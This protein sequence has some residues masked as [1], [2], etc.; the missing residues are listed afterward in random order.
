MEIKKSQNTDA[1]D[2][3]NLGEI[4]P[5]NQSAETGSAINS[6]GATVKTLNSLQQNKNAAGLF[7]EANKA[8]TVSS[9][10]DPGLSGQQ[11]AAGIDAAVTS[12]T[13]FGSTAL[14]SPEDANKVEDQR[15]KTLLNRQAIKEERQQEGLLDQ[16]LQNESNN[17]EIGEQLTAGSLAKG[18]GKTVD[19]EDL[20]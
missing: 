9:L 15:E 14:L 11:V 6:L 16:R 4:L 19:G 5:A 18:S 8:S 2:T 13:E 3:Q 12:R 17:E 1:A 20:A 10:L 7:K